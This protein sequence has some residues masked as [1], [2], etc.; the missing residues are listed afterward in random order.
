MAVKVVVRRA[1]AASSEVA[2]TIDG[3]TFAVTD[4]HLIVSDWR[5]GGWNPVAAY[6]PSEWKHARITD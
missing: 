2:D 4:G 1:S 5:D 6:A 3:S